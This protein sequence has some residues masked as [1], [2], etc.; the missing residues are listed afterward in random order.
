MIA[1][2]LFLVSICG[3]G[4]PGA[5]VEPEPK[6]PGSRS[7][8]G[9]LAATAGG[10]GQASR[11]VRLASKGGLRSGELRSGHVGEAQG[12]AGTPE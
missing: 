11:V 6:A 4:K 5:A 2:S 1:G 7:G 3:A 9:P 12:S 10:R 8:A